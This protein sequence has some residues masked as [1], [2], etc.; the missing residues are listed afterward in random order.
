[1]TIQRMDHVGVVVDDLE[2]A[3][4]FFV[5]LGMEKVG[6]VTPAEGRW[7]DQ[8]V[9]LDDVRVEIVFVQTPDGHGRLELTRF[10]HPTATTAEPDAPA[11]TIGLRR[12]MFAVDDIDAT[13]DRLRARGHELVGAIAQ[14]E[15]VYRLCYVRG[16]EG[17]LV[18]LAEELR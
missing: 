10:L 12:L 16:P 11:H 17:I 2:G 5:D 1:M 3:L 14:Y 4:A 15:D 18:A 7:V 6:E 13:V 8:V 9:G